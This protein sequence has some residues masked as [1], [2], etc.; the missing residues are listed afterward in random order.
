M[1]EE[2]LA[3]LCWLF[4]EGVNHYVRGL[5]ETAHAVGIFVRSL[6]QRKRAVLRSHLLEESVLIYCKFRLAECFPLFS[7]SLLLFLF[8]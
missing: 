2:G 4:F 5:A 7:H 8:G 6:V 1:I 3:G